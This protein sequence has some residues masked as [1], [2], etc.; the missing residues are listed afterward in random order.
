MAVFVAVVV[1]R[2]L[3]RRRSPDAAQ[4]SDLRALLFLDATTID[5][6]MLTAIADHDTLLMKLCP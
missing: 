3:A 5:G 2:P 4:A 6:P 1:R